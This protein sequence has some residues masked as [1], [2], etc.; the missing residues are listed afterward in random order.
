MKE[1]LAIM[2]NFIWVY[3]PLAK[4]TKVAL[5]IAL[6]LI[7][8]S[9]LIASLIPRFIGNVID[10]AIDNTQLAY[11]AI[12]T[13]A[14]MLL[15]DILIE[16]VRKYL[17]ENTAT[18]TQKELIVKISDRLIRLDIQWLNSQR[19]GGLNGRVQRSV[20]G[21]VSL[22]KLMT[23]DFSPNIFQMIFAVAVAFYTN[24]YVGCIL[25]LVIIIGLII[26]GRQIHS[27]KGI[28]LSLL[29]AR[30]DNDSNIVELLTGIE[31]VR[32]ANE[33]DKQM[34]RIEDINEGLRQIELKHHIK[35]MTFDGLKRFN[36]VFWN[37][38]ILLLGLILASNR[39]I[40]TGDIVTFNLLFNNILIPLQNI[41]RFI[42]EGQEASMKTSDLKDIFDLPVDISYKSSIEGKPELSDQYAIV[43]KHIYFSYDEKHILNDIS[44]N[45]EKGKYYG[46]IGAT[47][48]GKSTLLRT[49]MNLIHLDKGEIYIYGRNIN[50][51]SRED[52]SS[53]IVFMPQTPYIFSGTIR[54]NIL[55]GSKKDCDESKIWKALEQACLID[56]VKAMDD[57]LD[58]VLNER[59]SNVSGGQRQRI[60]LA[61][62]FLNAQNF[63]N[64]RIVILDEATSALDVV[65]E[66]TII[67]NI[68]A[69][70]GDKTTIIA[71]AHRYT[72][73]KNT[74]E[75][76]CMDNGHIKEIISY[77]ELAER[78]YS[79]EE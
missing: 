33:E 64:E 29:R 59:G 37:L 69:S 58:S 17:I 6:I 60:A 30:E 24:V 68:L 12:I 39:I 18:Q 19:S 47:G 16:V 34:N 73:L 66:E 46:I 35:M 22:L 15:F 11:T 57:Q 23:M 72:T 25:L 63:D 75:I 62:I 61:R 4:K 65:T 28:R 50:Q 70:V 36:I 41:H 10:H 67:D 32:V 74:Q 51:I 2:R 76:I 1:T 40:T 13:I 3:K 5:L 44:Y 55:F 27:Q 8:I 14:C 7:M 77:H 9:A 38:G 43:M 53:M 49:I 48:C 31:S 42:D 71:I 56:D 78:V 26:V 21:A 20:E 52:L 45:F 79:S 54:E